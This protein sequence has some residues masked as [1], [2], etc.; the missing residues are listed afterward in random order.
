MLFHKKYFRIASI[1]A[2]ALAL[3]AC[4]SEEVQTSAPSAATATPLYEAATPLS[5]PTPA[6][7]DS[8]VPTATPV[9][10]PLLNTWSA[11]DGLFSLRLSDDG[12]FFAEVGSRS[13]AGSYAAADGLLTLLPDGGSRYA[14]PYVCDGRTLTV[15]QTGQEALSLSAAE[16]TVLS[17]E[18]NAPASLPDASPDAAPEIACAYVAGAI[19]TVEIES[20]ATAADYCF[21]CLETPPPADASDWVPVNASFFRVYKFDG[22]YNL[23]V[24][25][26]Q[27]R[28]S[29]PYPITVSSGYTYRIRSEGLQWL[30]TPLAGTVENAGSSVDVLNAAIAADVASAGLYTRLGVAAAAVSSVSHMAELGYSIPYQGRGSYQGEN[31]WGLC[32]EWGSKL[33]KPTEDGNGTYYYKGMQCVGSLV[34]TYKQAG[35]NLSNTETGWMIGECG[36]VSKRSDNV[37]AY[38]R[39]RTGDLVQKNQHYLMIL[40]RLDTDG[41]GLADAYLTYEMEAPHLTFLILTFRTVRYR[42]F[43]NM[44]AVFLNE[45]RN[46]KRARFWEDTFWIPT[47]AMPAYLRDAAQAANADRA[48]DRFVRGV[49]LIAFEESRWMEG[50]S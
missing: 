21:T 32:P 33:S 16:G 2:L 34:W 18:P 17:V 26:E 10:D 46:R 48:L 20:G 42:T 50:E 43:F 14:V 7:T 40:D 5:T 25:D 30:K 37:I 11:K 8:P 4:A 19:V 22:S 28:V 1:A 36:A 13:A 45:G 24:R 35:L 38:D 27:G 6:P 12:T 44:D 15:L 9:P 41:D 31:D 3:T 23:F 49:G 39:A 47:D 29:K